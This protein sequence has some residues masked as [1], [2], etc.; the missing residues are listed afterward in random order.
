MD[1]KLSR[2]AAILALSIGLMAVFAGGRV[3]LGTLPDYYVIDW[4]PIYNF[5]VGV[6]TALVTTILLWRNGRQAM[7][8][9]A[10]TLAA[11]MF[12][13]L[14]LMV[15]YRDVVASDSLRAMSVRIVTWIVILALVY[16]AGRS[17]TTVGATT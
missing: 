2:L 10:G 15:G 3:L 5:T 14:I 11:H 12:V 8:A 9:A 13:M 6:I 7:L 16:F 1:T 17:R 4:L